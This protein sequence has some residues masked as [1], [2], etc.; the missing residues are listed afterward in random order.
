MADDQNDI[1]ETIMNI[2]LND[3][4]KNLGMNSIGYI[5]LMIQVESSFNIEFDEEAYIFENMNTLNKLIDYIEKNKKRPIPDG[6]TI[7]H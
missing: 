3:D 7:N 4:L 1:K 2:G 6:S 5:K